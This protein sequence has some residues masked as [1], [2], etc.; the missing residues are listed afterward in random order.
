MKTSLGIRMLLYSSIFLLV[1]SLLF[2]WGGI[3]SAAPGDIVRC[4]TK[5]G[6]GQASGGGSYESSISADGRYVAFLS[7]ASDLVSGDTN[8]ERD[9][10]RKDLQT[11]AIVRCSTDSTGTQADNSSYTCSISEDGRYVVFDSIA[12]NLVPGDTNSVGDVFRKDLQTGATVRCSTDSS[13]NQAT[14]GPSSKPSISAN[15]RYVA[16]HSYASN[17]V[18]GDTNGWPDIFRKDIQTGAI[19]RCS[20]SAGGVQGNNPSYNNS[21]SSDG[22]YVAFESDASILVTG[23]TNTVRDIF[24]K[25]LQTEAIVRC[26]T[27]AGGGQATGG[28]STYPD[29]SPDGRYVAFESDAIDLVSGDTNSTRDIFRKD[30]QT[31]AIARCSTKAGGV[32]GDGGSYAASLSADGRYVAFYSDATNLVS[33]DTNGQDDVF[34]KDLKTG[35]IVLC[36]TSVGGN[37]GDN[38]SQGAYISADG[39]YVAFFSGATNLVPGDTNGVNDVFRKELALPAPTITSI[40]PDE[41]QVG[42]EVTI[43]GTEFGSTRGSSYVS[44]G[45]TQATDYVSWSDT[46]IKVKVPAGVSGTVDVTVTTGSGTSNAVEFTTTTTFF[47]AE[48]YTGAGFSEWLCLGNPED[49]PVDVEVTFLFTDGTTQVQGYTVPGFSRLTVNVKDYVGPDREV[50]LKCVADTPFVAERPIYFNYQG[51]WDGGHDVVGASSPSETWYF[52][53][54]YTGSGFDEWICVLN[55]GDAAAGLTFRFQTQ[56]EGEKVVS[57]LSVPAHSRQTFKANDLLGGGSYQTSLAIESSEP[58]VAERPMYFNYQGTGGWNWTG[59]HCVMGVPSLA[60]D[61]YFAEGTTRGG[62][63]E[64]ITLQNPNDKPITVDAT[65]MLGTGE[66]VPKSYPIEGGKRFTAYVPTEV[67]ADQ[68]VSVHLTC[69]EPF[70]AERPMYFYYGGMGAWGWTGGHCVIGTSSTAQ[71]WF[72]AEGYTGPGFEEWLCIQNPGG[73]DAAVTITY[74]TGGGAPI[75]KEPITVAAGSRHTVFVNDHAGPNLQVSAWL[76]ADQPVIVERPMYFTYNGWTG[77]HD[78]VGYTP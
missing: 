71:D 58:V 65:Y 68:D 77:G 31:G 22:R 72:F 26:S 78:V 32:E 13:G 62:F 46:E 34:R 49:D 40:T 23:D 37:Q 4:S 47:F 63:E 44:F 25:D 9:V 15:G 57:G 61:Y 24:R 6:G 17:L 1:V 60:S 33:G 59:G 18:S 53:E 56:E 14:G 51:V 42:D 16:F 75:V 21:V 36:S 8:S 39:K 29:I 54:G 48:G 3:L 35:A 74:Y 10:F 76:A 7:D 19:V 27:K 38:H 2:V 69:P 66:T 73:T 55:P 52:A 43:A 12:T 67:G 28:S 11:G 20:T 41:G 45:A 5:A 30:I 64:W 50:S 70:L